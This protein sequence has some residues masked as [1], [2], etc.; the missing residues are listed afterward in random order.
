MKLK[1]LDSEESNKNN[2][3]I[4]ALKVD[5]K[6]RKLIENIFVSLS[7]NSRGRSSYNFKSSLK[8]YTAKKIH[9]CKGFRI[10]MIADLSTSLKA[11][12]QSAIFE[13]LWAMFQ[14]G[15]LD[16]ILRRSWPRRPSSSFDW[17]DLGQSDPKRAEKKRHKALWLKFKLAVWGS[18]STNKVHLLFCFTQLV[19]GFIKPGALIK[20]I[21]IK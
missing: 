13:T 5:V 14:S 8:K 20:V 12:S 15:Q 18:S 6:R 10:L 9:F 16:L 7:N 17:L 2:K 1:Y 11:F 4:Q 21:Q 19:S 3:D